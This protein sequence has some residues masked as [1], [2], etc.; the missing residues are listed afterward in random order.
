[1]EAIEG[2]FLPTLN[3]A[4]LWREMLKA[5]L[6]EETGDSTSILTLKEKTRN[7][8]NF[9]FPKDDLMVTAGLLDFEIFQI[10]EIDDHLLQK[11]ITKRE[12]LFKMVKTVAS[13]TDIGSFI[14]SSGGC[15]SVTR[16]PSDEEHEK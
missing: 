9:R 10:R 15:A 8:F 5:H 3:A 13:E 2:E 7:Q 1:M 4:L 14:M 12:F 6:Q 16:V 11:K